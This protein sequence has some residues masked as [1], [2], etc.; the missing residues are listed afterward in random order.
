MTYNVSIRGTQIR[1]NSHDA[2]ENFAI[3]YGEPEGIIDEEMIILDEQGL[4]EEFDYLHQ[5]FDFNH[6][7]LYKALEQAKAHECDVTV[8]NSAHMQNAWTGEWFVDCFVSIS[9]TK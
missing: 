1:D 9:V 6:S 5:E 4:E 8:H 2:H 7:D 3:F